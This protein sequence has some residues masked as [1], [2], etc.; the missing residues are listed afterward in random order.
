VSHGPADGEL[1]GLTPALMEADVA[2]ETLYLT[3]EVARWTPQ[4][5]HPDRRAWALLVVASLENQRRGSTR[6][7]LPDAARNPDLSS[8]LDAS[9]DALGIAA[10]E[11]AAI[12]ALAARLLTTDALAPVVGTAADYKPFIV[13]DGHLYHQ[14]V[15]TLERRLADTLARR[16][17]RKPDSISGTDLDRAMAA[18]AAGA[19]P[20][21]SEQQAAIR[22]IVLLPL[23]VVSGGPGTGKTS[24][25][26]AALR[27]LGALGISGDDVALC[28]A[29]GKAANRIASSLAAE[30]IAAGP[31]PVP[32]TI[33][34]LLGYRAAGSRG[35][36]RHHE[37][38]PLPHKVVIVDESS[39][40]DLALMERLARAVR[41]DAQLVLLGDANQ[42]P[43]VEAGAVFRDLGHL[44][45]TLTESHRMNPALPEGRAILTAAEAVL[46]GRPD[47]IAQPVRTRPEEL[48]FTGVE[49]L[50]LETPS[51]GTAA[52]PRSRPPALL[53]AFLDRWHRERI[54]A[55][56]D[57]ESLA[58]Q[59]YAFSDGQ[60]APAQLPHLKALFRAEEGH[61]ILCVT[62]GASRPTGA[63]AINGALHERASSGRP[64][65]DA[66]QGFAA[67]AP[68]IMLRNDYGRGLFNGDQGLCL[69]VAA[70]TSSGPPLPAALA[71]VFPTRDGFVEFPLPSLRGDLALAHALTV[72][73]AQGSEVDHVALILPDDDLPLL[74]RELL[75]T[76]MTRARRSVVVVGSRDIL[77]RGIGRRV[78]R[79]CGLAAR[80]A[81]IAHG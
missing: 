31:L 16:L 10:P 37:N 36:F 70:T 57:R 34:R 39:M 12:V 29:T 46:Q 52:A 40:I 2:A 49:M 60:P 8:S 1:A 74:S 76:A 66:S 43:S 59:T 19:R 27:A 80:L 33:H 15:L 55:Y 65:G 68:V 6:L 7:P 22:A 35:Q 71:A 21:S 53:N 30:M 28:A 4:L 61:R 24:I 25:I 9:L 3:S 44:A 32:Q 45:L 81:A 62:R 67:G 14:R 17:R 72:H 5:L 47:V 42:L 38:Y 18:A 73:R 48:T 50:A 77:A 64:A 26:V 56:P 63:D 54:A 23:T 41:D 79:F 51:K 13:D 58:Q 11:R 78:E 75:Y 69:R 20:L